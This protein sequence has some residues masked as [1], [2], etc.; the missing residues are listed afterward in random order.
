MTE[1][2]EA[3]IQCKFRND[4]CELV[5]DSPGRRNALSF[6]MLANLDKQLKNARKKDARVVIL[7]GA[8]NTFSAGADL[9]DLTG[10]IDDLALD[11]AIEKVVDSIL[12]LPV[13][14]T[15]DTTP[16]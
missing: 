15:C 1:N 10:T 11:D 6:T 5:L 12:A 9:N 3:W 14:T 16:V 4:V 2:R 7:A 8:G 13:G